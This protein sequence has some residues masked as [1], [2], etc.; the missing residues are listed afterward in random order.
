MTKRNIGAEIIEGLEDLVAWKRGEK[1]L[2]MFAVELPK[3]ADVPQIRKKLGYSQAALASLMSVPLGTLQNWEQ[4][5]RE[6]QGPARTLLLVASV[7]PEA[8]KDSVEKLVAAKRPKALVK[9]AA[10]AKRARPTPPN[11]SS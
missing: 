6:P 3:A 8:V 2:K 5:R 7:H 9:G 10:N 11:K 1:K 4:G